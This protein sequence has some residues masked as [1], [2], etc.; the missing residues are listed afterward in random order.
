MNVLNEA[1]AVHDEQIAI[2][3]IRDIDQAVRHIERQLAR[4]NFV[5]LQE[6]QQGHAVVN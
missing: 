6:I 1:L 3:P 2:A 4:G 5:T